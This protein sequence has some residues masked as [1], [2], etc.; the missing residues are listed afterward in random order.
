MSEVLRFDI[1]TIS[2]EQTRKG[3][4]RRIGKL[5]V[6]QLLLVR[7]NNEVANS[8]LTQRS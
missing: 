6:N 1:K 7:N 5:E 2:P 4:T 3:L 8:R